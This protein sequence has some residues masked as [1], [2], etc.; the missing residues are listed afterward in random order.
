MGLRSYRRVF[1]GAVLRK[2]PIAELVCR[3]G[4]RMCRARRRV[5]F[6]TGR[7]HLILEGYNRV[8]TRRVRS[9]VTMKTCRSFRGTIFRV[10]PRT[11]VGAIASTNLHKENKT[12]F[13]TKEG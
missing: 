13:P 8:S 11:I 2:R 10:A 4:N 12:K 6:C 5:P 3:S 1:R 7:A 9:T